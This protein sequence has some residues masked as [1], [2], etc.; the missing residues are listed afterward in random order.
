MPRWTDHRPDGGVYVLKA[1]RELAPEAQVRFL[2]RDPLPSEIASFE[3][4]TGFQTYGEAVILNP[5]DGDPVVGLRKRWHT[6]GAANNVRAL[7]LFLTDVTGLGPDGRPLV[8]PK[9]EIE[10]GVDDFGR[11][12][13]RKAGDMDRERFL[14]RFAQADLYEVAEHILER[15]HLTAGERG[16]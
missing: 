5:G 2:F 7:L 8:W 6:N 13:L 3:D 16:N 15:G 14:A 1:D 12:R 10:D 9:G 4:S 11:P